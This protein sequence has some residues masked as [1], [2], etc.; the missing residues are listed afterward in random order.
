MCMSFQVSFHLRKAMP[1]HGYFSL[2]LVADV[3]GGRMGVLP[4][5]APRG[6]FARWWS[7]RRLGATVASAMLGA[8]RK[9]LKQH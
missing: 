6:A 5:G 2:T 1:Q 4:Q 9:W 3:A 8:L 7:N